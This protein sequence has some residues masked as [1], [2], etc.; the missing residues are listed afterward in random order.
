MLF[1]SYSFVFVFF[2][3]TLAGFYICQRIEK[4]AGNLFLFVMS[5]LFYGWIH[6]EYLLVLL[7][8]WR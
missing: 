2:P 5:L 8:V 6:P 1:N 4:R 3:L 7:E